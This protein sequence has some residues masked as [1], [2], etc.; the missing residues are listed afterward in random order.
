MS[1]IVELSLAYV[2]RWF[3]RF[4]QMAASAGIPTQDLES[5]IAAECTPG[6]IYICGDDGLWWSAIDGTPPPA[7]TPWYSKAAV[8]SLRRAA[9]LLRRGERPEEASRLERDHFARD[10]V[11]L[12]GAVEGAELAFPQCF[13]AG[14]ADREL[15]SLQAAKEWESWIDGGSGVC[16]RHF[17]AEACLKKEALGASIKEALRRGMPD[18]RTLLFQAEQLA[19]VML[20]F[21]PWQREHCTP[22]RTI[23]PLLS[24]LGT[25]IE[26][27]YELA[28]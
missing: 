21:A 9:L 1:D 20:P 25:G 19:S 17:S 16:L 6:A 28:G 26:Y 2:A 10:F 7:G 23:D 27:P 12:I 8:W 3:W 24:A 4:D 11:T 5:L 13:V 18:E 14:Q 15:S 22:G